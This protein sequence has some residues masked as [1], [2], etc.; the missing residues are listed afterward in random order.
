MAAVVCVT[1]CPGS[2]KRGNPAL[3]KGFDEFQAPSVDANINIYLAA[4]QPLA[5]PMANVSGPGRI[6]LAVTSIQA[7]ANDPQYEYAAR[8]EL[9]RPDQAEFAGNLLEGGSPGHKWVDVNGDYIAFGAGHTE[10]SETIR[11]GWSS[12]DNTGVPVSDLDAWAE[13]HLLPEDPP[14][15]PFAVGYARNAGDLLD[16]LFGLAEIQVS[17]LGAALGLVRVETVAFAGYGD[18]DELPQ[19]LGRD[20][21]RDPSVS[22]LA[23]ADAGYPALVVGF[24]FGRFA[25]RAGLQE[26]TIDGESVYRRDIQGGLQMVVK[27]FGSTFYFAVASTRDSVEALIRSVTES[28]NSR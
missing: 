22:A 9:A 20:L 21:I 16:T 3:P 23:V 1:A 28:Q 15:L 25:G 6:E 8:L 18:I 12:N 27:R 2:A 17:G 24:L 5:I 13:L 26:A 11:A 4:D 14:A 10:W 19:S 7:L